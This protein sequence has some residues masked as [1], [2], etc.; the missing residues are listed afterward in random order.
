[1]DDKKKLASSSVSPQAFTF[2]PRSILIPLIF[3]FLTAFLFSVSSLHRHLSLLNSFC[4]HLFVYLIDF[5]IDSYSM[6]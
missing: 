6:P 2:I 4:Q 3:V 1:M 5:F